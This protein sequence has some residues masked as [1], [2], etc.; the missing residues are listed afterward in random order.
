MFGLRFRN[1]VRDDYQEEDEQEQA[2]SENENDHSCF[3]LHNLSTM[4]RPYSGRLFQPGDQPLQP[5]AAY[6][7]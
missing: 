4:R 6:A 1:Y 5:E 7:P 3:L 2:D